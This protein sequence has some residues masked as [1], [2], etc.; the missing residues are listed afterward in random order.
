MLRIALNIFGWLLILGGLAQALTV[1]EII[2][3][4]QAGVGDS[5]IEVLIKGD[6]DNRRAGTWK[7]KD[8]WIVHSTDTRDPEYYGY[9]NVYPW[10]V[11]PRVFVGRSR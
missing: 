10:V 8:G 3:L 9:P 1:D 5:T 11:A 2:R 4:K 6:G 7:T